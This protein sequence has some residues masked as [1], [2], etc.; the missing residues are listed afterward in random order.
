MAPRSHA[1]RRRKLIGLPLTARTGS[2]ASRDSQPVDA[3]SIEAAPT[4]PML[5][6]GEVA[7]QLRLAPRSLWRLIDRGELK[8]HRFGRAVRISPAD[9]AAF[10]AARRG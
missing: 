7:Q 5:R 8:V 1:T 9:L 10:V 4:L 3:P 6:V 2:S